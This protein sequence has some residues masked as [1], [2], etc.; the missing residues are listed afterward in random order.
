[1]SPIP[2]W[3]RVEL[4]PLAACVPDSVIPPNV[5]FALFHVLV[6][7]SA[8][9]GPPVVVAL[10]VRARTEPVFAE[11]ESAPPFENVATVAAVCVV[12]PVVVTGAACTIRV[13]G[14]PVP[15][16]SGA[17]NVIETPAVFVPVAV[18]PRMLKPAGVALV[19]PLP[20]T[21]LVTLWVEEPAMNWFAADVAVP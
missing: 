11:P 9:N 18:V 21:T 14:V 12:V 7:A 6:I 15:V 10:W 19:F 16:P 13:P 8:F 2:S 20:K 3:I 17:I 4:A 5:E 1:M